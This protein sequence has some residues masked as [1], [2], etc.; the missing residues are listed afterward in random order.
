MTP[1]PP[2]PAERALVEAWGISDRDHR[3]NP[4]LCVYVSKQEA[5]E[6]SDGDTVVPLIAADRLTD[7]RLANAIIPRLDDD[8][9]VD[10]VLA[11]LRAHLE[12]K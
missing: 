8:Y 9:S 6:E 5:L 10:D 3:G 4:Y 1:T 11:A 7:P 2:P 12:S